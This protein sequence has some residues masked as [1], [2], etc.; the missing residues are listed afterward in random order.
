VRLGLQGFI[1]EVPRA[2]KK[3]L[4]R[5][6]FLR[7]SRGPNGEFRITRLTA[8]LMEKQ[9][10]ALVCTVMIAICASVLLVENASSEECSDESSRRD[11][12]F[13]RVAI[14]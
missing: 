13:G 5:S 10:V 1:K 12:S 4:Y 8:K 2:R 9:R 11:D 3:L 6:H 7:F 14:V